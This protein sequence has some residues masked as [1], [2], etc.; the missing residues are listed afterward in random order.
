MN[1]GKAIEYIKILKIV[2]KIPRT[3]DCL[4]RMSSSWIERMKDQKPEFD[5]N[6]NCLGPSGKVIRFVNN[7]FKE[8][9]EA[10]EYLLDSDKAVY[11]P[12]GC[13]SLIDLLKLNEVSNVLYVPKLDAM[14]ADVKLENCVLLAGSFNPLHIGHSQLLDSACNT[15]GQNLLGCYELSIS[16]C[17]KNEIGGEELYKR[18]LQF[19]NS[20]KP[21]LITNRPYF[22]QKVDFI[23]HSSWFCIG[24]DTYKRFFDV[25]FYE[26]PAQ[27]IEFTEF[28]VKKGVQLLVG[29]RANET[30]VDTVEDYISMV[31]DGYKLSVKEV[32]NFRVD[33]SST[34]LRNS[35]ITI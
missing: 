23:D 16:N 10:E 3:E 31:P 7:Q 27:L 32:Q 34:Q 9:Y 11:L 14:I 1:V 4:F 8:I 21:L 20:D 2:D 35:K 6:L 33:I 13:K 18:I 22:R 25:K 28:L 5:L 19:K 12:V 17:S 24:A 30:K 29:P 15:V 26:S